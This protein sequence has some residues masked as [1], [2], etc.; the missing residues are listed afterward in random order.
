L[1]V[2]RDVL[3]VECKAANHDTPVGWRDLTEQASARLAA[4]HPDRVAFVIFTI[5]LKW[6]IFKGD[7][8]ASANA[9]PLQ[10]IL[11]DKQVE[12]WTL[13][14]PQPRYDPTIP[15]QSHVVTWGYGSVPGM[16]DTVLAWRPV[17]CRHF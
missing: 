10:V 7:P 4:V 12:N 15:S 9:S 5:G 17:G 11:A 13:I 14:S 1:T 3:W 8:M 2:P 6:R 16:I